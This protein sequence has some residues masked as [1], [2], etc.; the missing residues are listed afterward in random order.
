[1]HPQLIPNRSKR[2]LISLVL[3]ATATTGAIVT[4]SLSKLGP[5][6]P[7]S[8]AIAQA[9]PTAER[10]TG[11]GRLEPETE[12]IQLSAPLALDGDRVAQLLVK[13]GDRVKAEQVIAIL[14]SRD[15][16]ENELQQARERVK[17]AE[18]RLA[19]VKAGAK[20]GEIAAQAA[21]IER[22]QAQLQGERSA[23]EQAV[24]RVEA[25][26]E[27]D[28]SAQTATIR[29]LE[30]ELNNAE[31]EYQRYQ[32]L[33]R[34]GAI[35]SS[36]IDTKRL[37]AE[38][39]RQQVAEA[40]AIL[41]RIETTGQRQL[42]EAKANLDRISG[43]GRQQISEAQ[44]TLNRIEEVRPVDVQA[45]QTE[46]DSAIAAVKKAET[47]LEQAYIRAPMDAQVI[48]I[49]TRPGEKLSDNGIVELG[50]T[51]RMMAI[52]EVYQTDI[53]KIKLGQSAVVRGQAFSGEAQGE[54]AEIGRQ[55]SRQNVF[56]NQP[57]ENLDKRVVEVKIR[58]TLE[59]SKR[60]ASL[61]NLQVETAIE[62]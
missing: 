40:R 30:A 12:V 43:T 13:A 15:R 8:P 54:V 38:T 57:G 53:G 19:Q 26:T 24:A 59:D 28:R 55:V 56:S 3:L 60:V 31:S 32:Q 39:I 44:A 27:G 62:P 21:T 22:V 36:L 14:D 61:T 29:R 9:T 34:E 5:S 11:L 58:L 6:Q 37:D 51:D 46:V 41:E 33:Y 7:A 52:A 45:A 10:I 50:Q 4:Y 23:Q 42:S 2:W 48:K 25:Q 47:D 49:H 1:M 20:G 17:V 35:S 18:A 16:L